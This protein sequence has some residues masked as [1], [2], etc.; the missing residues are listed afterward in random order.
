MAILRILLLRKRF[1]FSRVKIM[2]IILIWLL[3]NYAQLNTKNPLSTFLVVNKQK[4][5]IILRSYMSSFSETTVL[6]STVLYIPLLS[7]NEL[8]YI[9]KPIG[10]SHFTVFVYERG[11]KSKT[12]RVRLIN[13]NTLLN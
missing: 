7:E 4:S 12:N 13:R 2:N 5:F 10:C 8:G 3:F 6:Y 11:L 1:R 9:E